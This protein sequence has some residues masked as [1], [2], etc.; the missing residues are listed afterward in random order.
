MRSIRKLYFK[1]AAGKRFGLNGE[2]GVYAS[3]LAGFGFSLAHSFADLGRGFFPAVSDAN[4]PQNSLAFVIVLTQDPYNTHQTLI[5]WL[6][7]ADTLTL[8]YNPTGNREYY[9]DVTVSFLQKG[10]LT[11]AGWLELPCSFTCTTPWYLPMPTALRISSAAPNEGKT[12]SYSFDENLCYGPDSAASM[13]AVIGNSGHIPGA[14]QMTFRGA[15]S[16]PRIKLVGNIS[17]RTIGVCSLSTVLAE[18]DT[19][20]F[21]TRYEDSYVRKTDA[22]GAVTDLL[23][24]LDLSLVPFY[25]VPVDEP[26]AL[27]IEAD[28]SFSGQAELL[29]YY[30]FRSV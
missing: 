28:A 23:D 5:D 1:N 17:G 14:L 4:E 22:N 25:R 9:R 12:Y 15:I 18:T 6:S 21:S 16:N 11:Q 13:G 3:S 7:A 8:V 26:C 29:I 10:E 20:T 2:L 30:Y 24:D 19:L 27:S